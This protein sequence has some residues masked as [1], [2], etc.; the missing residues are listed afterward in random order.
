MDLPD[1][2]WT[3]CEFSNPSSASL[4]R[5]FPFLLNLIAPGKNTTNPLHHFT[6]RSLLASLPGPTRPGSPG[7]LGPACLFISYDLDILSLVARAPALLFLR[8]TSSHIPTR[9]GPGAAP[10]T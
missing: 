5:P 1:V 3:S 4:R 8:S 9:A 10:W 7:S 6:S 2:P